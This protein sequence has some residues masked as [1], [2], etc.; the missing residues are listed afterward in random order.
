MKKLD[1]EK[2]KEKLRQ[3]KKRWDSLAKK[4]R[5]LLVAVCLGVLGV[6]LIATLFLNMSTPKYRV[7]FP[8]MTDSEAVEVYTTLQEMGVDAKID[9]AQRV[10]VPSGQWDSLVFEL[11][12]RGYPKTTLSY[13][14][15]TAASGFTSTEFEKRVA[16][17][18]QAQDRMQQTLLRQCPPSAKCRW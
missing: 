18:Q 17:V 14:T 4:T 16:L 5:I 12:S 1:L 9:A 6:A 11:N 8:G 10:M 13:D 3:L 15:F 2:L 7:I